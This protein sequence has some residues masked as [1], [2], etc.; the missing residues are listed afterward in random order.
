MAKKS[1]K[2]DKTAA[3]AAPKTA[4]S[5]AESK[6][7]EYLE[8]Q[9]RKINLVMSRIDPWSVMKVTFLLSV[10]FGVAM[11][12]AS[13]LI[14]VVLNL[15]NVFGSLKNFITEIDPTGAVSMLLD[16]IQL[17]RVLAFTTIV[18]VLNVVITT[19]FATIGAFLYNL[20]AALVGG[21]RV[22]LT[23]D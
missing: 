17:P 5:T 9:P 2:N 21:I 23:D 18:S 6:T 15:M 1:D 16:F 12:A 10:C 8:Y 19:A 11:V 4:N 14:W 3:S 7:S 22:S 13:G 20:S